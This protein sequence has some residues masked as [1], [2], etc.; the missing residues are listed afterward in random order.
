[1]FENLSTVQQDLIRCVSKLMGISVN[2][3]CSHIRSVEYL[4]HSREMQ[5][6]QLRKRQLL[7]LRKKRR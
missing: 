2:L 3:L 7:M 4:L 6:L 5:D 1:M